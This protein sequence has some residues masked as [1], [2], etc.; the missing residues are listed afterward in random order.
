MIG[1]HKDWFERAVYGLGLRTVLF[2]LT[3]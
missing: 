2:N 1:I 3:V